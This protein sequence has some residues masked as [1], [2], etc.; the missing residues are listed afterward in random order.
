MSAQ[1]TDQAAASL[2]GRQ[3][4][5]ASVC[6]AQCSHTAWQQPYQVSRRAYLALSLHE[7]LFGQLKKADEDFFTCDWTVN[8][9]TQD[10]LLAVAGKLGI[11]HLL[12]WGV[13]LKANLNVFLVGAI[14]NLPA[15]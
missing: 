5:L 1:R 11:I 7:Y 10:Y 9:T 13:F 14:P 12:K 2:C 4:R 8:V 15:L 3:G 6:T